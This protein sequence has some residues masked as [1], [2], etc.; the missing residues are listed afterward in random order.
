MRIKE[1]IYL[2]NDEIKQGLTDLTDSLN[3]T[4]SIDF[5]YN[6]ET[7]KDRQREGR[8][9]K[10]YDKEKAL[11]RRRDQI[12]LFHASIERK[13]LGKYVYRKPAKERI[14]SICFPEHI[15]TNVHY[16]GIFSIPK[17]YHVKFANLAIMTWLKICKSGHL[18]IL[19]LTTHEQRLGKINYCHKEIF[20]LQNYE[21]FVLYS[22]FWSFKKEACDE[23]SVPHMVYPR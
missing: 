6:Y 12:K 3:P 2:Q 14:K 18:E 13:L 17:R 15:D 8:F 22:E 7:A 16:H 20:T 9:L 23:T 11:Q 21:N 19:P 1:V 5:I 10:F 4:H